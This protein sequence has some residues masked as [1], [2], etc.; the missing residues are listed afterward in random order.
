LLEYIKRT[1]IFILPIL[2]TSCSIKT[3]NA[4]EAYKHWSGT[5]PPKGIKLIKGEY[6]QSPHFSLEYELFLKF[7]A[8]Y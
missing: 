7:E 4:E 1:T 3:K 8:D 6:Y 2:L 5:E